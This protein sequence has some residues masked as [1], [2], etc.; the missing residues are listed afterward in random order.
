MKAK[1]VLLRRLDLISCDDA[2]ISDEVLGKYALLFEQPLALDV[3]KAFADFF[4][5]QLPSSLPP[6]PGQLIVA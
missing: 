1:R 3:L 5:W 4:G 2:P 6:T